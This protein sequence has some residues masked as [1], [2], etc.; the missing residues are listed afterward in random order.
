MPG[1]QEDRERFNRETE[2]SRR[3]NNLEADQKL[4]L[5]NVT[6]LTV[7]IKEMSLGI[8]SLQESLQKISEKEEK[9]H[10]YQLKVVNLESKM[11]LVMFVG[12]GIVLSLIGIGV[13]TLFGTP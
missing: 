2:F 6:S 12:A 8:K 4:L 9:H 5:Q 10:E 11:H 1:M 3:I 13:T 7:S